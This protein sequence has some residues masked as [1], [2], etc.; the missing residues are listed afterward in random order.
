MSFEDYTAALEQ[1]EGTSND[2]AKTMSNNLTG[3]LK[4]LQSALD[5]LKLKLFDSAETPLRNLVKLA[6]NGVVPAIE[7]II[8]NLKYIIPVIVGATTAMATFKASIAIGDVV[9]RLTQKLG[10]LTVAQVAETVKTKLAA[11]AWKEL[12]A[13]QKANVI[14]LVVSLVIGLAGWLGT[15]LTVTQQNTEAMDQVNESTKKY[16]ET[17]KELHQQELDRLVDVE[18]ENQTLKVL[19]N[20]YETLKAK[21]SLTV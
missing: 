1:C 16:T 14:G 10:E 17:L 18:A 12:N 9:T 4:T 19:Q 11:L 7:G 21:T 3:D 8:E 20:E 15:L 6:T 2:M 5:E 13:A